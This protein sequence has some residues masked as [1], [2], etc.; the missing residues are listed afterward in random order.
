MRTLHVVVQG[1]LARRW[2]LSCPL[3]ARKESDCNIS[4][5][6]V[7][8]QRKGKVSLASWGRQR[9]PM[10]LGASQREEVRMVVYFNFLD[11]E[12]WSTADRRGLKM[13]EVYHLQFW[14]LKVRTLKF[15]HGPENCME[16]HFLPS[17]SCWHGHGSLALL[18]A[19]Q[20]HHSGLRL[21]PQEAVFSLGV[22]VSFLFL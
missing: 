22:P 18:C 7:S 5:K 19:W 20:M 15:Q 12:S 14:R 10:W 16:D 2:D 13:T 1:V 4:R 8:L 11:L 21:W 17:L 6:R 9:W 3:H